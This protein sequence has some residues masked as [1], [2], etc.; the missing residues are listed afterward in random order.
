MSTASKQLD[1]P[2][3]TVPA[4]DDA[5]LEALNLSPPVP[6]SRLQ[7]TAIFLFIIGMG[8]GGVAGSSAATSHD[9]NSDRQSRD[10]SLAQN[11]GLVAISAF[12][13]AIPLLACSARKYQIMNGSK[14]APV[15]MVLG[16]IAY[17]FGMADALILIVHSLLTATIHPTWVYWAIYFNVIPY[18]MMMI[19]AEHSRH[20]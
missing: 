3:T 15:L 18:F 2:K 10:R 16:W 4:G 7:L 12:A 17:G 6:M 19:H 9:E 13:T 5:L 1:C 11:L 20:P 8:L 14:G